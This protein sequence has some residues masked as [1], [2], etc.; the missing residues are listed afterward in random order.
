MHWYGQMLPKNSEGGNS[1][2]R[3]GVYATA[4]NTEKLLGV[5]EVSA[6]TAIEISF[7][8]MVFRRILGSNLHSVVAKVIE[9]CY[10]DNLIEACYVLGVAI[11]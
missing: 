7:S 6:N 1:V 5:P 8:R 4:I 2:D 3:L 11:N 9:L 10:A